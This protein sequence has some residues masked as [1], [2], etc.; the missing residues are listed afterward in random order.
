MA[1]NPYFSQAVRSEQSLY[2]D[3]VI[4]SLKIYGQDVYYLPRDIIA[5]DRILGEDIPSRFNSS[6]KV[7][8]YIEN[9]DGFD[10]EGDLFT[11]FGVEIR[12]QA[13]FIISRRRWQQTVY[14]HDNEIVISR[15][16]EGD[17]LYIPFSKKLFEIT[18]VEHEQPFYQL[19][20]L[21]TFKLRC[22]LFEYSAEDISTGTEVIDDIQQDFAMSYDI[23]LDTTVNV[24]TA[25]ALIDSGGSITAINITDSGD[26]YVVPPI[27]SIQTSGAAGGTAVASISNTGGISDITITDSSTGHTIPPTV[28]V[29]TPDN[30]DFRQTNIAQQILADGTLLRGRIQ[31]WN[32]S[33]NTLQLSQFGGN[34]GK[35]H[36][37]IVGRMF[38][39][40]STLSGGKVVSFVENMKQSANEQNEYFDNLTDFLDFSESNPFGEP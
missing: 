32:D 20:N 21:P 4:E 18:H 38:Y 25:V 26:G 15:P 6:Y 9:V 30:A 23:T 24:A 12:D 17:I 3:I 27:V 8:M 10:G 5:E 7:E 33:D 2:E 1:T 19:N 11:K 14:R 35:Y 40:T 34:D 39:D 29:A 37:P 36:D 31:T 22:E 28:V 16:K 13:T